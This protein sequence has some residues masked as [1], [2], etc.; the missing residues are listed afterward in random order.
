MTAQL[1]HHWGKTWKPQPWSGVREPSQEGRVSYLNDL[2]S[3]GQGQEKAGKIKGGAR[4]LVPHTSFSMP[5][6]A[7]LSPSLH[8]K[9]SKGW[10]KAEVSGSRLRAYKSFPPHSPLCSPKSS[11]TSLLSAPSTW[12]TCSYLRAFAHTLLAVRHLHFSTFLHGWLLFILPVLDQ[13]LPPQTSPYWYHSLRYPS[14]HTH[15]L[16]CLLFFTTLPSFFIALPITSDTHC[17]L[18]VCLP[19]PGFVL[20][21]GRSWVCLV[22]SVLG[23]YKSAWHRLEA[24]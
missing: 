23:A 15:T 4:S 16:E 8:Y 21:E 3:L 1:G 7:A 6:S 12:Q 24:L 17:F 18:L 20:Q 22:L 11:H 9:H 10:K 13:M 14:Q 2:Q 5:K 19:P